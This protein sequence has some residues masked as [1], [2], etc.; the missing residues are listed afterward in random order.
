MAQ[1]DEELFDIWANPDYDETGIF[2]KIVVKS[3]GTWY[4][5]RKSS[6]DIPAFKGEYNIIDKWTDSKGNILYKIILRRIDD[7]HHRAYY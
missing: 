5:Y 6:N 3:E 4:E 7:E 2:S 1:E